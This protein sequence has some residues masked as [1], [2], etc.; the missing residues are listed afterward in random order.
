MSVETILHSYCFASFI[1]TWVD[2]LHKT[3]ISGLNQ[4]LG[5]LIHLT[6]K[7]GFIQ[8][9]MVTIVVN[10]YINCGKKW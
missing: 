7:K 6:H 8:I 1:L 10:R 2:G 3:F 4:S 9:S 5:S